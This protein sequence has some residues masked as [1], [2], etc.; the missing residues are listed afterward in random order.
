MDRS[1]QKPRTRLGCG[2]VLMSMFITCLLLIINGLIVTAIFFT[3]TAPLP[4]GSI[5]PRLGQG[6]VFLGPILLLLVEWWAF[7]V[8]SDWLRPRPAK[9]G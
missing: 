8:A 4:P 1:Q 2:Y 7:D 9:Q 3:L 5:H 6:I